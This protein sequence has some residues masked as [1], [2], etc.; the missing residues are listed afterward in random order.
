MSAAGE[1][2]RIAAI[3]GSVQDG[4]VILDDEGNIESANA[5]AERQLGIKAAS[6]AGQPLA[7]L[8]VPTVSAAVRD[9]LH[10]GHVHGPI[11]LHVHHDGDTSILACTMQRF[12]AGSDHRAGIALALRDVTVQREFDKM[13]GEFV[14]RAS[15]ELRT[16]I[17]SVRMG[18]GL[19]G[20]KLDFPEG[21]RDREL[22]DTV[23][24][25]LTRMVDLLSDLLDL[26]RLR[27]GEHMEFVEMDIA[28]VLGD[29]QQRFAAAAEK[30]HIRW[31]TNI[32]PGL[33][34]LS[35]SRDAI[36]RV[37]TNLVN[38]AL[39]H[40]PAGGH[41]T[42]G[43]H[44][45]R[46]SIVITVTDNGAGISQARQSVAFE[47]FAHAA[48]PIGAGLGLAICREIVRQHG[49]E[50]EIHSRPRQGT[51]FTITLPLAR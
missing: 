27:M 33:P 50:I 47:P 23:Q 3:L 5:T 39:S 21:S 42:L 10:G 14:L 28:E 40:T 8:G 46:A 12:P 2:S 45:D 43:A 20:E 37:C 13:C 25:E 26:S 17:A 35:L 44:R 51:Q 4:L 15:H 41:V 48:K 19:L 34:M 38:N 18:L 22:Y 7:T 1:Q 32:E 49:G 9:V 36:D 31:T 29:V 24:H 11:E 6:A 16:P 30:A